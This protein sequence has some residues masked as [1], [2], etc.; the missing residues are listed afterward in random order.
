MNKKIWV[1]AIAVL[2]TVALAGCT[3]NAGAGDGE[4][5]TSDVY[6]FVSPNTGNSFHISFQCGLI[7]AA[8][9]AGV[10][11]DLQGGSS[12]D[13][14]TQ[15]PIVEAVAAKRPAAIIT[16]ATDTKALIAPLQAIKDAGTHVI[17]YDTGLD[18]DSVADALIE[19][20][21]F[22]GGQLLAEYVGEALG[23]AGTILTIDIAPGI[24]STN[25]RDAGFRDGMKAYPGVTLLDT[26]YDAYT[27][28]TNAQIVESTLSAHPELT[29]I[30][31]VYNDGANY[32]L[33]TL[34]QTDVGKAVKVFTF[35]L[36]PSIVSAIK[37]G[38]IQAAATQQPYKLAQQTLDSAVAAV[39]GDSVEA[40][41]S[42][43]MLLVTQDNIDDE[44]IKKD[45]YYVTEACS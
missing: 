21:N 40:K 14:E 13:A 22:A 18:D 42:V 33:P 34:R 31:P 19:S 35:D 2:T 27:P 30:V 43:P 26:Q 5:S 36:D 24:A 15:I 8:D 37:D 44:Q 17:L 29:A 25:A 1:G 45:G 41:Q 9:E 32:A 28:A 23:G 6:A 38:E 20:D 7:A 3:T 39:N 16:A 10:T 11:L 12:F 4:E